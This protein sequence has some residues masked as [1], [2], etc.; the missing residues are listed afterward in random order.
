MRRALILA[1]FT[2]S[3][4]LSP[5]ANADVSMTVVT[6]FAP[7]FFTSPS[8]GTYANKA[9][10]SL[11]NGLGD[12]GDRNVDP[13]AYEILADGTA[14]LPTELV[15][16]GFSSWRGIADQSSPF[17]NER[18]NRVH[19]G[20]HI[21]GDGSTKFRLA[22]LSSEISSGDGNQLGFVSSFAS[23]DYSAIRFGIDYGANMVKGGGDDTIID[24]GSGTQFVDEFVYVGSGNAYDASFETG[25]SNQEKIDQRL[26]LI[27]PFATFGVTG[28]Y[29]LTDSGGTNILATG[30]SSF[31]VVP[32]PG[33]ALL[34]FG[35]VGWMGFKRRRGGARK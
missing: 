33:S 9:I 25:P 19:F 14:V 17:D 24:S 32:E 4:C 21:V 8:W 3:F 15:V 30:S 18:G 7:N 29:T 20:I 11:E 34:L 10:N 2:V 23:T 22:D 16:T 31:L 27:T 28:S 35:L 6:S 12:L 13:T 1:C 26:A 5:S